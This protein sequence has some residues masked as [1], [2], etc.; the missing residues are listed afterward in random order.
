[1][2]SRIVPKVVDGLYNGF[3]WHI[4]MLLAAGFVCPRLEGQERF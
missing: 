2:S 1:M 4:P 3:S